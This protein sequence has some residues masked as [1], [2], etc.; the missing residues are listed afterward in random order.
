MVHFH[1]QWVVILVLYVCK[2]GPFSQCILIHGCFI[3]G[4]LETSYSLTYSSLNKFSHVS[5]WNSVCICYLP[6]WLDKPR[7]N[8]QVVK[9][10]LC[11]K[12]MHRILVRCE[13][14]LFI[15]P[16]GSIIMMVMLKVLYDQSV[17]ETWWKYLPF[18]FYFIFFFTFC[19][20]LSFVCFCFVSL[21]IHFILFRTFTYR[22]FAWYFC[23]FHPLLIPNSTL[24]L[25]EY[26]PKYIKH[27]YREFR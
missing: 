2:N 24:I 3:P 6:L 7:T 23:Q 8:F 1:P 27:S 13:N 17:V 21:S 5:C 20:P 22:N 15:Q 25:N 26:W 12:G 19:S 14:R 16:R 4:N 18:N 11:L 10:H 9:N